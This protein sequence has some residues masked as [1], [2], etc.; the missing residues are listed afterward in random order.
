MTNVYIGLGSNKGNRKKN[1]L[2]AVKLL[3]DS[4]QKILKISS[5]YETKPYGYKNQKNFTNAVA[6]LKTD[7]PPEKLLNLCKKIEKKVGRIHSFRWG[8]RE[9]DIDILFYGYKIHKSKKLSIPHADLHN[10]TFVL[11]PL[12]EL[13][14]GFVHPII[15]NCIS[16]ILENL[17][18]QKIIF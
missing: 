1:I 6:K 2:K 7:L 9:I 13:A 14:P 8:P 10:R 18:R 3:K 16:K 17:P 11:L 15:R 12:K 5:F 4:G